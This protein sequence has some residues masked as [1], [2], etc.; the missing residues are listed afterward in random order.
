MSGHHNVV[1]CGVRKSAILNEGGRAMEL[2]ETARTNDINNLV[3]RI[4]SP[5]PGTGMNP[6]S[7]CCIFASTSLTTAT[8]KRP[9]GKDGLYRVMKSKAVRKRACERRER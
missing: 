4:E 6:L 3:L 1:C 9:W 5:K 7:V 8:R 2:L